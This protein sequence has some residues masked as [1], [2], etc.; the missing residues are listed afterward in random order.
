[1]P[2]TIQFSTHLINTSYILPGALLFF[3]G[4]FEAVP[5]FSLGRIRPSIAHVMMGAALLWMV[6]IHMSW[7]LL[8]PFLFIAWFSRRREGVR[9]LAAYAAAVAPL[10]RSFRACCCCRRC[11]ATGWM[12]V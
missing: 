1:M 12:Q 10:A 6:Q 7:L 2:W 11:C 8:L 5:L 4:F 3:I 9:P